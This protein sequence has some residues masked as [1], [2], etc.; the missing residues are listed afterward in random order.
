MKQLPNGAW[1]YNGTLDCFNK[2]TKYEAN[3]K[4]SGNMNAFTIGYFT[5]FLR[6]FTIFYVSMNILDYYQLGGF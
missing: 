5:A 4:H 3:E 1:P 2:I 6:Y